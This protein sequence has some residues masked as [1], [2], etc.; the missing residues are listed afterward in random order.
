MLP[1]TLRRLLDILPQNRM[2]LP[3]HKRHQRNTNE[4]RNAEENEVH[5][6][7]IVAEDLVGQ[8][9]EAGLAEVEDAGEADDEAV[10]FAEGGEAE[11]FGGVVAVDVSQFWSR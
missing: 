11:D 10:D 1:R 8:R 7:G 9:V 6:D 3:I 4:Q 2:T 5:G